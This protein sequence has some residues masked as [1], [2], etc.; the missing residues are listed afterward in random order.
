MRP[1]I[2]PTLIMLI[3]LLAMCHAS[4]TPPGTIT[5]TGYTDASKG[6][7]VKKGKDGRLTIDAGKPN[8]VDQSLKQLGFLPWVG[9]AMA[10]LGVGVVMFNRWIPLLTAKSGFLIVIAGVGLIALPMILDRVLNPLYVWV[11]T[12]AAV[13][14]TSKWWVK[15]L[16]PKP[17]KIK[18]GQA[19]KENP[20]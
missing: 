5:I 18:Q 6:P 7:V 10:I 16:K 20:I 17:R 8:K 3:G 15:W 14:L 9:A 2:L 19:P 12:G 11:V 13:L 4:C 1:Y